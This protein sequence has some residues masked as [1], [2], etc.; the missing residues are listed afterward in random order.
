M[1]NDVSIL[2]MYA[3]EYNNDFTFH[4]QNDI[5]NYPGVRCWML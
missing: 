2:Y 1:A 4:I 5:I 3:K